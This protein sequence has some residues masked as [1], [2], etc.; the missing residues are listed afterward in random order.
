MSDVYLAGFGLASSMGANLTE[1]LQQLSQPPGAQQRTVKGLDHSIPYFAIRQT[2]TTWHARCQG[3]IHQVT[4]EAGSINKNGALYI[5]SSSLNAGAM[6]TGEANTPN[7][8]IFLTEVADMLGWQGS[9][10]LINTACTSGLNA[11]LAAYAAIQSDAIDEALI[12]GI[13]LENQLT[14]AGFAGMQLLS[15]QM[16][17]P[18]AADRNGLVLGEA[19]A[20]LRLSKRPARWRIAGGAQVIDSSQASGA[21]TDAY[22]TMLMQTLAHAQ[23]HAQQIDLIKVQAAGSIANDEVEAHALCNFFPSVPPLVSLKPLIGHTLGASG[24]AEIALLLA[25]LEHQQWPA[26]THATDASLGV[27]L[28]PESAE[29]SQYILA[30]ILGFGGSH[31]CVALEDIEPR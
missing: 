14:L 11:L 27:T 24:A 6:E 2:T 1:A 7:L 13:E 16:G 31:T 8:P 18:F 15:D 5:A 10:H 12:I 3:L 28:A 17:R 29:K 20:A 9:V 30:C 22:E 25:M 4:A 26:I 21:S 23:W 19:I